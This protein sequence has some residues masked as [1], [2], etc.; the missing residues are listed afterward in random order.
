MFN[1]DFNIIYLFMNLCQYYDDT[2]NSCSIIKGIRCRCKGIQSECRT[3]EHPQGVSMTRPNEALTIREIYQRYALGLPLDTIA[4]MGYYDA[5]GD[6]SDP[7]YDP[8]ND[9]DV[10][11]TDFYYAARETESILEKEDLERKKQASELERQRI[12]AE[13]RARIDSERNTLEQGVSE[14]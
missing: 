1:P 9:G 13:I 2:D 10:D 8:L 6:E 5:E 3:F 7:S 4:R 12:E 14:D 11:L